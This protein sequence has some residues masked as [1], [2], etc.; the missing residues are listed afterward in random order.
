MYRE[1]R[2][3]LGP[4]AGATENQTK[5][6][7]WAEMSAPLIEG[8]NLV[9]ASSATLSIPADKAVIAVD[10]DPLG[11]QGTGVSSAGSLDVLAKPLASATISTTAAAIGKSGA[12]SYGLTN[13]WTGATSP[14][15]LEISPCNGQS[16]Q[17]WSLG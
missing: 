14:T 11:K 8:S 6:S 13:L 2:G 3:G 4:M 16:N 5:F 9:S 12:S 10:Q 1:C 15:Q 7:L 17:Q